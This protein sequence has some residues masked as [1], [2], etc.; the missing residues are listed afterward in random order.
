MEGYVES[1]NRV[2]T[3]KYQECN[4]SVETKI[5]A[6]NRKVWTIAPINL[7]IE[8][9]ERESLFINDCRH[10]FKFDYITLMVLYIYMFVSRVSRDEY[11]FLR[12]RWTDQ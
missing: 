11:I 3:T 12:P 7:R 8:Y 5:K 10:I 2:Y 4:S 1:K 9:K 6:N